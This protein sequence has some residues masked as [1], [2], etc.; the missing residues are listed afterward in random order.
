MEQ[1]NF[2]CQLLQ[3]YN[4]IFLLIRNFYQSKIKKSFQFSADANILNIILVIKYKKDSNEIT[5]AT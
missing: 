4:C 3:H 5:E 2:Y 1:I